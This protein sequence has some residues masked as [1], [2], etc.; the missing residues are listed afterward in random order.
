MWADP[1]GS[2]ETVEPR[3]TNLAVPNNNQAGRQA[4]TGSAQHQVRQFA[5]GRFVDGVADK[6]ARAQY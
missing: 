5:T 1:A 6:T 4:L 2:K 3:I